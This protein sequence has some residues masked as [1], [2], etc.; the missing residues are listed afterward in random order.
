MD[1]LKHLQC[2]LSDL[3][4]QDQLRRFRTIASA[5][6]PIIRM[7][8]GSEK[9]LLCSNNY[10]NLATDPRIKQTVAEA[11]EQYGFGA[12]ASRLISGTMSRHLRQIFEPIAVINPSG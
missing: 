5:Q 1:F 11:M 7:E 3:E 6:G 12:A 9:V 10:L 8:D 4:R 2:Q